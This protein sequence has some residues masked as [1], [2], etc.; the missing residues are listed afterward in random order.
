VTF[1]CEFSLFRV[2]NFFS[3]C[4]EDIMDFL[5]EDLNSLDPSA[6]DALP[7]RMKYEVLLVNFYCCEM[8][9]TVVH[10]V[11]LCCVVGL[12]CVALC[13][14]VLCYVV[15]CCAVRFFVVLCRVLSF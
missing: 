2:V 10:C 15:C 5:P 3:I 12:C 9:T 1:C 7:P 11:V 6:I 13:C 14:V 8:F 4:V